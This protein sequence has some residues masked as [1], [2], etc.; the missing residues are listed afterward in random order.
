MNAK[1]TET[2]IEIDAKLAKKASSTDAAITVAA[3]FKQAG[4][5]PGTVQEIATMHA[6]FDDWCDRPAVSIE[7][8]EIQARGHSF[9][10]IFYVPPL[11]MIATASISTKRSGIMSAGETTVVL[12][13]TPSG[14][15]S[16]RALPNAW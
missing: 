15:A 5:T 8:S 13:G 11:P 2:R 10:R 12:E 3:A 16:A 4:R 14:N 1:P 7:K 6:H 9:T